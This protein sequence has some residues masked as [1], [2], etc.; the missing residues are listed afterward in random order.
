MHCLAAKA[1]NGLAPTIRGESR[2]PM[3]GW[4]WITCLDVAVNHFC[5]SVGAETCDLLDKLLI[6]NPKER[7]TATQALD[8]DYFWTDPLPADPKT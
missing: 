5:H 3:K 7:F 1:S 4:E 2:T 8:H 6:C